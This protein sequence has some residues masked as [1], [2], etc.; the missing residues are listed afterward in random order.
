[1]ADKATE[2]LGFNA[3]EA[4]ELAKTNDRRMVNTS[5]ELRAALEKCRDAARSGGHFVC[6]TQT[7]VDQHCP[8]DLKAVQQA[9]VDRKFSV[10]DY[11]APGWHLY[12]R[13]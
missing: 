2:I 4:R 5:L 11:W 8:P 3:Q 12:V 7:V 10:E 6:V 9:L 13:W 1:M